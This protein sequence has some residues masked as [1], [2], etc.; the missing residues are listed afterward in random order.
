M[1]NMIWY[2]QLK[3]MIMVNMMLMTFIFHPDLWW[4]KMVNSAYSGNRSKNAIEWLYIYKYTIYVYIYM[5]IYICIYVNINKYD[6]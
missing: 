6:T 4:I 3:S 1:V 2:E 5:Y